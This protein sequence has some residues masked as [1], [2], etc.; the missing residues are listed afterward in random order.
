MRKLFLIS[1]VMALSTPAFAQTI[2]AK[3][4]DELANTLSKYVGKTALSN[5]ILKVTP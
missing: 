2:D 4:A 3:G 1:C 5:G